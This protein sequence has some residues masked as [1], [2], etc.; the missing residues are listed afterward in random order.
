MTDDL[1]NIK[2]AEALGWTSIKVRRQGSIEGT[3]YQWISGRRPDSA[4]LASWSWDD[5]PDYYGDLNEAWALPLPVLQRGHL[6]LT[7]SDEG[8]SAADAAAAICEA[9]LSAKAGKE[10]E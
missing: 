1:R 10:S 6:L 2:V 8:D 9:F 7:A 3:Q 5:V 4:L